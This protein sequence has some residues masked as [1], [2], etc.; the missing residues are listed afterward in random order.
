MFDNEIVCIGSGISDASGTAVKTVVENR[1]WHTSNI[2]Y[3]DGQKVDVAEKSFE[4]YTNDNDTLV[5]PL[6]NVASGAR[7]MYFTNMGGYV[8]LDDNTVRYQKTTYNGHETKGTLANEDFLKYHSSGYFQAY[9]FLEITL[10]HGTNPNGD[11]YEYIYLPEATLEETNNYTAN[12]DVKVLSKSDT[13]HAV[14]ENKLGALG[15]IFYGAG[16][17]NV[18][19]ESSPVTRIYANNGA[20]VMISTNEKG[21]TVI[22]VS[23]PTCDLEAIT[24]EV[25][26]KGMSTI[27]DCSLGGIAVIKGNT[28]VFN[29]NTAGA[30]GGTFTVTVA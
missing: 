28:L 22:S 4:Y 29:I 11:T 27:K 16:T 15:A 19:E 23:E 24:V 14:L 18:A 25:D 2:L 6:A 12:P 17:L 1:R 3:I 26:V 8:F 13:V 30:C 20:C 5:N 10:D 21:E 9:S 7:S